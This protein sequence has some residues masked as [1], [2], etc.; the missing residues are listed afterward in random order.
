MFDNIG[1]VLVQTI[2]FLSVFGYFVYQLLYDGKKNIK[3]KSLSKTNATKKLNKEI[4][5][6][7]RK[8]LFN[9]KTKSNEEENKSKKKMWFN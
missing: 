1:I 2:G 5:N 8:G 7:N 9:K 6:P 3:T 4:L